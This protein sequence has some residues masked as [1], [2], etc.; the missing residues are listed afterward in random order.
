MEN[1]ERVS[2]LISKAGLNK[3]IAKIVVF[4]SEV[5]EAVS[6]DIELVADLRQPQVSL[7]MKELRELGWIMERELSRKG[8][9]RP[10]RSYKL[11]LE[12]K[13]IVSDLIKKKREEL[14]K[15]EKNLA[16]LEELVGLG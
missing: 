7:A 11:T 10:K 3:N 6:R 1:R 2:E 5:K 8:K 12:L 9:G 14:N 13:E 16:E 4:L 15:I